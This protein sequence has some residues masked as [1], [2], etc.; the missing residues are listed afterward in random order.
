M[1]YR[2]ELTR[3]MTLLGQDPRTIVMGQAV[4][5]PGTGMTAT[6]AGVPKDQLLELPVAEDMQLGMAIGMSLAGYLPICVFPRWNFL[7]AATDQLVNHLDKLPLY[8]NGWL[9]RTGR[10]LKLAIDLITKGK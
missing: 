8:G 9:A 6:F 7:L 3:A 5:F 1:T 4:A 10:R 2:T